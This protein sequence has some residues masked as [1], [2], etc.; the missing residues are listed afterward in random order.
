MDSIGD[1]IPTIY[2]SCFDEFKRMWGCVGKKVKFSKCLEV[3]EVYLDCI[4]NNTKKN[5]I[6]LVDEKKL[7]GNVKLMRDRMKMD[8][9]SRDT[10]ANVSEDSPCLKYHEVATLCTEMNFYKNRDLQRKCIR[11]DLKGFKCDVGSI[12]DLDPSIVES[13]PRMFEECVGSVVTDGFVESDRLMRDLSKCAK[14]GRRL[15]GEVQE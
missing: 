3:Q 5:L 8:F 9:D 4:S 15:L 12:K 10:F 11:N 6:V 1:K 14:E 13:V 7:E 2:A